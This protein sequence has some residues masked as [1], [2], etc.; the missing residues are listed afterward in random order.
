M[1]NVSLG[2]GI[3][4]LIAKS[5]RS[6][7]FGKPGSQVAQKNLILLLRSLL[8][9]QFMLQRSHMAKNNARV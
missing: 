9:V 8:S 1:F 2:G 3:V 4:K 6:V 5:Q 7:N